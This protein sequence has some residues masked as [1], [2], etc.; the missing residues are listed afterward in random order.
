MPVQLRIDNQTS[1]MQNQWLTWI[2]NS[3]SESGKES[4]EISESISLYSEKS[5]ALFGKRNQILAEIYE[6]TEE[7][8]V[9]NW[10]GYGA[11]P[12]SESTLWNTI[13]IIRLLPENFMLP[14]IAPEPDGSISLDWTRGHYQTFSLSIGESSQLAYAWLDGSERG[15]GVARFDFQMIPERILRELESFC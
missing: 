6:M 10:D 3:V 5:F 9:E 13:L 4:S 8:S 11:A 15:H 2:S 7:C 12:I 1:P 14:E